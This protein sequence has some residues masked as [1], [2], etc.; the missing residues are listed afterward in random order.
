MP[1][2]SSSAYIPSNTG[3]SSNSSSTS[4]T[5]SSTKSW[6]SF[7]KLSR[8]LLSELL[9]DDIARFLLRQFEAPR[10]PPRANNGPSDVVARAS[11]SAVVACADEQNTHNTVSSKAVDGRAHLILCCTARPVQLSLIR[12]TAACNCT[13]V[14]NIGKGKITPINC[15]LLLRV[16]R[17]KVF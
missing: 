4:D 8:L 13:I 5:K 2:M 12:T 17:G 9:V 3:S 16:I 10:R 15:S 11:P 14:K 7:V 1:P 6:M